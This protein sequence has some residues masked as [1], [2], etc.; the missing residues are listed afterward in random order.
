MA[1]RTCGHGGAAVR[2]EWHKHLR[3]YG[4]RAF[5]KTERREAKQETIKIA[6]EMG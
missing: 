3:R 4:K 1:E 2:P 5:W 6:N